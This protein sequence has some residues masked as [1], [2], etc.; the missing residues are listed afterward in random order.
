M[1]NGPM[2]DRFPDTVI[3][4]DLAACLRLDERWE[5]QEG[6][7]VTMNPPGWKHGRTLPASLG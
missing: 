5:L 3:T 2:H 7:L 4:V 6:H 1:R